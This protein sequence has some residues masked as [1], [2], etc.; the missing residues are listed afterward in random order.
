MSTRT[1]RNLFAPG[2]AL[3]LLLAASTLHA[4]AKKD[5]PKPTADECL[6]CHSDATLSHEVNGKTVSLHVD[7]QAFKDSIHGSMFTCVDCHTDVKSSA[8]ETPPQHITCATCHADEQAAYERSFHAKAVKDGN[9]KAAT[10][11][12]CHGSPHELLPGGRPQVARP[13]QQYS[14]D[15]RSVPQPEICDG[16]QRPSCPDGRLV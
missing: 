16:G 13:S 1:I 15:M 4:A 9:A 5:P 7:P 12:D 6:A 2:V 14:G 3:T 11:V 10:C 8:H